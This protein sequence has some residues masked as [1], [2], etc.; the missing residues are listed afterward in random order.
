M[1]R[2][3]T[4]ER[5]LRDTLRRRLQARATAE[6]GLLIEEME[7]GAGRIDLALLTPARL[8]GYELKSDADSL[9]RLSLQIDIYSLYFDEVTLVT[10]PR[11]VGNALMATPR[12]WGVTAVCETA[13]AVQVRRFR[14]AQR[15]P[16]ANTAHILE[17]LWRYELDEVAKQALPGVSVRRTKR[18]LLTMLLQNEVTDLALRQAVYKALLQRYSAKL[19]ATALHRDAL[20]SAVAQAAEWRAT[21][22]LSAQRQLS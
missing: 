19:R 10:G 21:I 14:Q 17:L 15:N 11:W 2:L 7:V 6:G 12:F 9:A 5:A 18:L 8:V 20:S 1:S 4:S 13:G 16:K 3:P 22:I